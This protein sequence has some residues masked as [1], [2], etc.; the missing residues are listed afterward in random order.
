MTLPDEPEYDWLRMVFY[1]IGYCNTVQLNRLDH[2]GLNYYKK[3]PVMYWM[4]RG[5]WAV[6]LAE[7]VKASLKAGAEAITI[8]LIANKLS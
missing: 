3:L 2:A 6:C 4:Q 1:R 7:D 5:E 8:M